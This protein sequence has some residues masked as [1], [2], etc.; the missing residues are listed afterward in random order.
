ME[1]MDETEEKLKVF[2]IVNAISNTKHDYFRDPELCTKAEKAYAAFLVNKAL[3]FHMDTILYANE[4][5]QRGHLAGLLQHDY[6]INTVR[7]RRRKSDKW[8]KPFDDK[9]IKAVME[10]YECNYN[11]A[12]EYLTVLTVDQLSVIHDRI[13]KG[14]AENVRHSRNGGGSTKES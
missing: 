7:P 6:L 1:M 14:G 13:F 4:M 9:D 8:P 2:D 3:S 12:K 11:R 5:N 10:Y